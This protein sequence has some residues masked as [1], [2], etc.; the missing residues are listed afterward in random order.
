MNEMRDRCGPAVAA[1][2][3]VERHGE[4]YLCGHCTNRPWAALCLVLSGYPRGSDHDHPSAKESF[5]ALR[6]THPKEQLAITVPGTRAGRKGL[7]K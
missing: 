6:I 4:L 5:D 7:G 3:R 1:V 2:Y